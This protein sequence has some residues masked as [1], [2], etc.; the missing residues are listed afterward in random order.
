MFHALPPAQRGLVRQGLIMEGMTKDAVFLAWG[1][2]DR[3]SES[4][5]DGERR[6]TWLYIGYRNEEIPGYAWRPY[7]GIY[8]DP[9]YDAFAYRPARVSVPY[10]YRSVTFEDGRVVAY[11]APVRGRL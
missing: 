3:Y 4:V 1:V 11:E 9:Y 5:A 6:E 8:C 7:R 10:L 2:P